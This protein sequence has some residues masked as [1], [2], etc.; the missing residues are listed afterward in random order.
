MGG[1]YHTEAV[2]SIIK[3]FYTSALQVS[4]AGKLDMVLQLTGTKSCNPLIIATS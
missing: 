1:H 4:C 2:Q 3:I